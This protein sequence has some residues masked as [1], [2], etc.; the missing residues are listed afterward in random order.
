MHS[1]AFLPD[2]LRPQTVRR[3]SRRGLAL[4]TVVP[5]MLLS[6]PQWR[7]QEVRVDGCSKLP[8]S[9]IRSLEELAGAPALD[10]DLQAIRDRVGVWPGIGEVKVELE[11]PATIIVSAVEEPAL[12]SV[13]IGRSWH[14][15]GRDGQLTGVVGIA[16]PPVLKG[17]DTVAARSMALTAARRVESASS[18]EV[19]SVQRVTPADYRMELAR[20][21]D[22]EATVIHVRPS[23]TVAELAWCAA[24]ADGRDAQRWADLRWDDRMVVGSGG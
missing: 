4:L 3:R 6:L 17:F 23:A 20:G 14:G 19:L 12:G 7:V 2:R 9:E 16:L 5:V 1:G 11:L 15:V 24:V 8:A 10:V 21:T 13:R 18:S 22:A